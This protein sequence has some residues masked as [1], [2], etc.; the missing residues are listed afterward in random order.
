MNPTIGLTGGIGSGKSEAARLFAS[1]GVPIIDVDVISHQLT[2]R[3]QPTL[4]K[5]VDTFGG[6]YLDPDG[7]L[8]RKKLRDLVFKSPEALAKLE[9]VMHPAIFSQAQTEL[10]S[11]PKTVYQVLVVPLLFEGKQYLPFIRCSLVIDCDEETQIQ[12]VMSRSQ[13]RR[14]DVLAIMAKQLSRKARLAQ[15]DVVINNTGNLDEFSQSIRAFHEKMLL[16]L[17]G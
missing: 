10:L 12:R 3:G 11:Q 17:H 5:L 4:A 14:E 15:A 13:M 16:D 9:A 2:E 1:F 8:D 7:R 6:D